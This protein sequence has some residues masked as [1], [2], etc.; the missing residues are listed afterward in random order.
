MAYMQQRHFQQI[1]R[2]DVHVMTH[3]LLFPLFCIWAT[4]LSHSDCL[5]VILR[6][7]TDDFARHQKLCKPENI[8]KQ[9][10]VN[11]FYSENIT[12][13]LNYFTAMLRALYWRD[14]AQLMTSIQEWAWIYLQDMTTF[15]QT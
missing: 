15:V 9:T 3:K 10:H 8:F 2:R 14:M 11:I 13:F 6:L 7:Y 4:Y 5:V 1:W 12:S